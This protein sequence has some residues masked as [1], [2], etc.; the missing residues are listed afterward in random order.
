MRLSKEEQIK[1]GI[2]GLTIDQIRTIF[3]REANSKIFERP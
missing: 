1:L 3:D 2:H